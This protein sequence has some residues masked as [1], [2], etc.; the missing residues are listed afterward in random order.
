M[1]P[2]APKGRS[3]GG[4]GRGE[5]RVAGEEPAEPGREVETRPRPRRRGS[6]GRERWVNAGGGWGWG[7]A[8]GSR[9][10][11]ALRPRERRPESPQ[12]RPEASARGREGPAGLPPPQPARRPAP[13]PRP[14][15]GGEARGRAGA[16]LP[17][18]LQ[19]RRRARLRA[20]L[21]LPRPAA[22]GVVRHRAGPAAREGRRQRLEA[23]RGVLGVPGLESLP[24]Q[25]PV[26]RRRCGRR[27][28]S[29]ASAAAAKCAPRSGRLVI[30]SVITK[31]FIQ[32]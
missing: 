31:S 9:A 11:A 27:G 22:L 28:L 32:I 8:R 30:I 24:P 17:R 25:R 20:G 29:E 10:L 16:E 15:A 6:G 4:A 23:A 19:A 26:A 1:S 3:G 13:T 21:L 14:L 5:G 12:R 7:P 2:R 18:P